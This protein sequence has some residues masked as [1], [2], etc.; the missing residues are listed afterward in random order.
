M[1]NLKH[2]LQ[3][4]LLGD[5]ELSIQYLPGDMFYDERIDIPEALTEQEI[6]DYLLTE[7]EGLSPFTEEQLYWGALV[8][9]DHSQAY[10]YAA[11]RERVNSLVGESENENQLCLPD[12]F[13]FLKQKVEAGTVVFALNGNQYCALYFNQADSFPVEETS[14]TLESIPEDAQTWQMIQADMLR[15]AE[16]P[17]DKLSNSS[18]SYS[19][20]KWDWKQSLNLMSR[21]TADGE[22]Q[23]EPFSLS[24]K[25]NAIWLADIRSE[26][27]V[28]KQR[29]NLTWG[30]RLWLLSL[31]SLLLLGLSG[32]FALVNMGMQHSLNAKE[33]KI[34]QQQDLVFSIEQKRE[35]LG[36]YGNAA[37]VHLQPLLMLELINR[38]RPD[39]IFFNEVSASQGGMMQ[40]TGLAE[41]DGIR[42][43]R[44]FEDV[45]RQVAEIERF[46]IV[47]NNINSD[48]SAVFTLNVVFRDVPL[49]EMVLE[50]NIGPDNDN[51]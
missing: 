33:T 35:N 46:D 22:E 38:V 19:E 10:L 27:E 17:A 36:L 37:D 48:R 6:H 30:N 29:N 42:G 24:L 5:T 16:F 49:Q 28:K 32:V 41:G 1:A 50:A 15:E 2:I 12:Y 11:T 3:Q 7:L 44:S 39:S 18:L 9:E 21:L 25:G 45:L 47:N 20:A 34:A 13:P 51:S 8:N 31:A 4:Q 43:V 26:D 23:A 40:I 14:I